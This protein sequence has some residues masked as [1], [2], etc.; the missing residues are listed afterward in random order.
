[1]LNWWLSEG[2]Y[3]FKQVIGS[4]GLPRRNAFYFVMIYL[5]S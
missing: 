3:L 5:L 1:M 2:N 4:E